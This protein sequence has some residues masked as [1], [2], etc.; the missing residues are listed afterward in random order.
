MPTCWPPRDSK[1][2]IRPIIFARNDAYHF[3]E[4]LGALMKTGPTQTNVCDVRVVLVNR[5]AARA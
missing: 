5:R 2:S 1:A 4:P 3:F